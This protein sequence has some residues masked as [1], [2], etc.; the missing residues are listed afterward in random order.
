MRDEV[1]KEEQ[2]YSAGKAFQSDSIVVVG[3]GENFELHVVQIVDI[4]II[5]YYVI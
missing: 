5:E 4:M 3:F 2:H 1:T